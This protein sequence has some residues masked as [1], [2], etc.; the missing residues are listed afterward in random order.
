MRPADIIA[1]KF[2]Y[3]WSTLALLLCATSAE[4]TKDEGVYVLTEA[5]FD[6]FLKENPTA[7]IEFY[8]PWLA[9]LV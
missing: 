7:L 1:M 3:L 8:A 5:N 9:V 2:V 4:F 6:D